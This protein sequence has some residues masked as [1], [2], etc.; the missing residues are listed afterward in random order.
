MH[1]LC[2]NVPLEEKKGV[3]KICTLVN[4]THIGVLGKRVLMATIDFGK[5]QKI[6]WTDGWV[7]R[8][9]GW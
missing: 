3:N 4:D 7:E 9:T 8:W 2:T 5:H 1:R 6:R